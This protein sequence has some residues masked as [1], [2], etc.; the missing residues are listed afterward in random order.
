MAKEIEIILTEELKDSYQKLPAAIQKKF[1]K[2]L[3]ILAN[4]PRHPSLKIHRLNGEWEFY[5]DI[6]YRC[7]FYHEQNK[8]ILLTVGNHKIVDRY[9]KR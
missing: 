6:H 1:E 3:R 5:I 2:Q 4:N 9:K 8:Y 7:F